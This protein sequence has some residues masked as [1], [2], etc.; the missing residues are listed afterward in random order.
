MALTEDQMHVIEHHCDLFPER[1]YVQVTGIY[2]YLQN[3]FDLVCRT[4]LGHKSYRKQLLLQWLHD[5]FVQFSRSA[6][7]Q[8]LKKNV[9]MES[10]LP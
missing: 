5:N 6:A 2:T 8:S 3:K 10:E 7:G 4:K 1:K 9:P